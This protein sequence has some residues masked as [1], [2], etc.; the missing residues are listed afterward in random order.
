MATP[1]GLTPQVQ[2]LLDNVSEV[3]QLVS[4]HA[5]L[6]GKGPGRKRDVEVLNKSAIVLTV[7]CWEAFVEDV[8]SAALTC[9]IENAKDHNAFPKHVLERVSSKLQGLNAWK[10]SGD[11]WKKALQNNYTEILAKTTGSL[12][13]PRT[14]QVDELFDKTIGLQKLS[15]CWRWGGRS[16]Q[17]AVDSLDDL[18]TLRCSIAHRVKHASPVRK[19]HVVSALF[20]VNY[21]A[22]KTSNK[23]RLHVHERVGV[24]PWVGVQFRNVA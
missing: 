9:M 20:L 8:A 1:K 24:Y 10:L 18:V 11:G 12:N 17:S 16:Q 7:A 5:R 19:K 4:I 6:G 2:Q 21:L 23:V 3:T 14:M 15:Q 13:T 22:A